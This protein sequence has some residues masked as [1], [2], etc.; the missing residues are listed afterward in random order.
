M[1][2]DTNYKYLYNG[3]T[4]RLARGFIIIIFDTHWLNNL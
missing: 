2:T 3:L 4:S 1:I